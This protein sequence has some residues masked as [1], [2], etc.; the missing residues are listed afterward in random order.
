MIVKLRDSFDAAL[1]PGMR[2][3]LAEGYARFRAVEA[4][5]IAE[6]A[7]PEAGGST[8]I[9]RS[10]DC[11]SCDEPSPSTVLLTAHGVDVVVCPTCK[12]TYSR[13]VMDERAD[14]ARYRSSKLDPEAVRLHCSGPYLELETARARYYLDRLA[15]VHREPGTLLEI[16][17]GT[18]TF[19]IEA[20][21][22]GWTALALEPGAAA[23]AVARERGVDVIEGYFPQDLPGDRSRFDVIAVLDVLEHFA[24]PR[25]FLTVIRTHLQPAGR[26]FIQVPNW[27]S[28]LVQLE[29][30]ASSVVCPGH[31]SYFTPQTLPDVLT[32]VGFRTVMVETVVS[33][34]DRI[35]K[36]SPA[37]RI[38]ALARLRPDAVTE[39]E[40]D[41]LS[42][43][44]LHQLGLGYKLIG[45]FEPSA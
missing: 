29:G 33:E 17:C 22:K 40:A 7:P 41:A 23:A 38:A 13:Q 45:T 30:A 11:P 8:P 43:D 9:Y 44:Q 12:L 15:S 16:G 4:R 37:E 25:R 18:G 36:F 5:A 6:N 21:R 31:W 19:V 26:L 14:S 39:P 35:G 3:R 27:D 10:R 42:P 1:I 34:I 20:A 2:E 28:L 24:D 32:R